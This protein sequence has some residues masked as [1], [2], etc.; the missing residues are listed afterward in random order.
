M[1]RYQQLVYLL[2]ALVPAM[3]THT[4]AVGH[5]LNSGEN[6][7]VP[8]LSVQLWS[9][10]D[11]LKSDFKDTLKQLSDMGFSAVEL[12]GEFGPFQHDAAG[13]KAYLDSLNLKVSGAHVP[14]EALN[15]SNFEQTLAFYRQLAPD[16][17]I[18][19]WDERAWHPQGIKEVV[20]LL[21]DLDKKL[22]PY[23]IKTGFHNHDREFNAFEGSTY[24]DYLARHTS[25]SVVLQQDVGWT[26]YAGKDPV[27]YV[28]KYPGRTFTTHYKVRLPEGI[29]GKL[30]LIGEDTIDWLAL[31]K[32]N[33]SVG[34]TKWIVIEQ[35][36]YPEGLSPLAAIA[37]S[38]KGLER[39][40]RQL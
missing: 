4:Y 40:I 21:N 30:P 26:T 14:F 13:L 33:I 11:L 7:T 35:E 2:L 15:A 32:A 34:G 5:N 8:L 3:F 22:S 16:T 23:N 39:Y 24:W 31:L 12:A 18:I 10:K 27:D 19:G 6:K 17:L 9:V 29:K 36:E 28:R 25:N 20:G 1:K 38:K 37:R